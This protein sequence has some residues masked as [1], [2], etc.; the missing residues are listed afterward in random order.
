MSEARRFDVEGR[1]VPVSH[2]DKELLPALGD[3]AGDPP[4]VTKADLA[5]YL[6]AQADRLL[7]FLRRRPLSLQRFPDGLAGGGFYQK[8]RPDHFPGWVG[9]CEVGVKGSG[10][11]QQQ[12]C[13]DDAA[14]LVYLADQAVIT[15]HPWLSRADRLDHPDRLVLDLDP[16]GED[17]GPVRDAARALR[18]QL[19]A[20]GLVAFVMTTGSRG[21][22]VVAPLDRTTDFDAV[23]DLAHALCDR[24][25]RAA[26]D[27]FTTA[28]RKDARAGRVFLDYLRNAYGQTAVAPYSVRPLPGGPV[29]TPLDWEELGDGHLDARRDHVGNLARRLGQKEDPWEGFWRHAGSAARAAGRL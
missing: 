24:A 9:G 10:E 8:Q 2:P 28:T 15:P 25:A 14:A 3:R 4:A 20:A 29:A 16:P 21:L 5:D 6:L 18:A 12:V 17:L 23:R 11:R 27:R 7:P 1:T 13:A 22:H 19:E 26:P